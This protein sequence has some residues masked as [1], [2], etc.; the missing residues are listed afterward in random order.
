MLKQ[1]LLEMLACPENRSRLSLADAELL[2]KVNAAIARKELK[3]KAGQVLDAPL[4]GG[5]VRDD[6]TILYPIVD[7]IPM[8]LVDQ[9]IPL[10]QVR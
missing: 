2:G 7:D 8:M 9:A 6:A 3:N 10:N 5:L 4:D 1:E